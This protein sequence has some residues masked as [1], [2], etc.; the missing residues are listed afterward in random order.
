MMSQPLSTSVCKPDNKDFL[1]YNFNTTIKIRKLTQV[2]TTTLPTELIEVLPFIP[3]IFF[4]IHSK[5]ICLTCHSSF[6]SLF[7]IWKKTLI[8]FLSSNY[9][10]VLKNYKPVI[11]YISQFGFFWCF[12]RIRLWLFIQFWHGYPCD[13]FSLHPIRLNEIS[14]YLVISNV[15]FDHFHH[16]KVTLTFILISTFGSKYP[17]F[18][19]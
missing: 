11:L 8:F 6:N 5:I 16:S 19:L 13:F 1:L 7:L 3:I 9:S 14:V 17:N 10:D 4:R 15:N 18:Y 2:I 12:L